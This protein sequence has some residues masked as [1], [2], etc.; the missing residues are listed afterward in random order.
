M[1]RHLRWV[2][3]LFSIIMLA[4]QSQAQTASTEYKLRAGDV[5]SID[6]WGFKDFTLSSVSV[7][8][9]GKISYPTIGDIYVVDLTP[10]ALGRLIGLGVAKY[11]KNPKV[12]VTLIN[13]TAE[14]Y[15]V[16]GAVGKPS[17]Y[18]LTV[19]TGIREAVVAAGDLNLDA[20]D[21]T[22]TL[23]RNGERIAVDLAAAMKGDA[24]RN[25][26][27]QPGDTLSID[28]ALITLQGAV[29]GAGQQ[30]LRRGA[31]LRQALASSGDVRDNADVERIQ[32]LRGAET[33]VVNL[34]DIVADPTKD[35]PL[36]PGD[37]IKVDQ[38]DVRSVPVFITGA[39]GHASTFRFIPGY[40]DTIQDAL[41]WAGGVAGDADL[42]R[43]KI[44]RTLDNKPPVTIRCDLRTVEGR[45][46]Q[47]RANDY[48]EVPRKRRSQVISL[49]SGFLGVG[50]SL[51]S[52]LRKK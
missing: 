34:R 12:V 28:K 21:Q 45:A 52:I 5:I 31:T 1:T 20:N 29:N 14:R 4:A 35:V 8:P 6:V 15:F 36:K 42:S 13:S 37:I 19:S 9:D 40:R 41:T 30:P 51:Y 7:R 43:A 47:L 27:L 16:T 18:P 2:V 33:I 26:M 49:V 39:V 22:A 3:T 38:V 32:I 23:L 44:R 50:L 10:I 48:I 17:G 25:M 46:V 11:V 24:S